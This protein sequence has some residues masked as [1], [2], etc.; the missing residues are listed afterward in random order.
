MASRC[1]RGLRSEL[2]ERGRAALRAFLGRLA[3]TLEVQAREQRRARP[4]Q[5]RTTCQ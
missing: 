3:G 4:R 5:R 2:E 1:R